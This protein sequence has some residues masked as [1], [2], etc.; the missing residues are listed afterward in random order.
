[1]HERGGGRPRN[2]GPQVATRQ[3]PEVGV[4]QIEHLACSI[5]VAAASG[6]QERGHGALVAFGGIAGRTHSE[7][8]SAASDISCSVAAPM[9]TSRQEERARWFVEL[10][11]LELRERDRAL[12]E[13]AASDPQLAAEVE[14]LLRLD[15]QSNGPIEAL[16]EELGPA[17]HS[18]F[19]ELEVADLAPPERLGPWRLGERL[20]AGGMGE[21]WAAE[22]ADAG[23]AQRAAIKLVR[24][25][26]ASEEVVRRFAIER[27]A[28][29]RLEHP[30]IARLLDGGVAPDGRPWFAMERVDGIAITTFADTNA[31]DLGSRLRLFLAVI[32]S[33]AFAHQALVVHRD[34]KPSNI[35]VTAAG[36]PKVLD[37]G[38]AKL[39]DPAE[40][41]QDQPELTHT[42]LLA[43]TPAYAAPEQFLGEPTTTATD[44]YALGAVLFELLTG[45]LPHQR[46]SPSLAVLLEGLERETLERPS[47]RLRRSAASERPDRAARLLEGDID[48]IVLQALAREPA[49]RYPTVAALGADI[50]AH[51]EGRPIAARPA[52]AFYLF[53]KFLGRHRAA[54]IAAL[55]VVSALSVS[56]IVSL[57][58]TAVARAALATAQSEARRAERVKDFL[59]SVFEQA[60][61]THTQGA[62][63]PARQIL[64]EGAAQLRT[65]LADE[66]EVRAELYDTVAQIQTSLGLLEEGLANAEAGAAERKRQFGDSSREYARS[67]VT[68][69]RAKLQQAQFAG[70]LEDFDHALSVFEA[71]VDTRSL[72]F[73]K[74]LSG[75]AEARLMLG[76][77]E[78]A[79]TDQLAAN[80]IYAAALGPEDRE[81]LG[82]LSNLAVIETRS[83]TVLEAAR[84]F[85]QV[86]AGL[87][88]VEPPDSA[89]VLDVVLN[90]ATALDTAGQS[91]EALALFERVVAGRRRIYGDQHPLL[92]E[93]LVIAGL[94]MSRA[95]RGDDALRALDEARA[96]Y[97]PLDHPELGTV[98]NF[99]GLTYA[100]LGRFAEAEA[101]FA[102]ASARFSR[103]LGPA[104]VMT[105]SANANRANVVSEL[106]R[107]D[108]AVELFA[109]AVAQLRVLQQLDNP[110]LL[111]MR[112]NWG[113]ALRRAGRFAEA[114][115]VLEAAMAAAR[116]QFGGDHLRI[117]EGSVE[118]ARLELAARTSTAPEVAAS[119]LAEAE[120][121]A[122]NNPPNAALARNLAAARA[123]L[124]EA[125]GSS[126]PITAPTTL[127]S[128]PLEPVREDQAIVEAGGRAL[129]SPGVRRDRGG[130]QLRLGVRGR[131]LRRPA[132]IRAAGSAA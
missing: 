40:G 105:V 17:L 28:L 41:N 76:D 95:G 63:V 120:R 80:A 48:T 117:A 15:R 30:G 129:P 34:L 103:D 132:A 38:L 35:L 92:A 19:S 67:R 81:T 51:L 21:V 29:A 116:E 57:Q 113:A 106:G 85:R 44:V 93:A 23:F 77:P 46:R 1:M 114:R 65:N 84:I 39:L 130:D 110:R 74:A 83:G 79:R 66:P 32:E 24:S 82:Q 94:R 97:A 111:R 11:D 121:I 14:R 3:G 96:I 91:T 128:T 108:E 70:A 122:E 33:V 59:V 68:V 72:D 88:R 107:E 64:A 52:S 61:P 36:A 12:E 56:L 104:H 126:A 62:D 131:R 99:S 13:I 43:L 37:F 47:Q 18:A 53:S 69:G 16:R 50:R 4:D 75:R 89:R 109:E 87:E 90:L 5:A 22:R 8:S 118:L 101:A 124:R 31:L 6:C 2:L 86:L 55:T 25:N 20:G 60:D 115:S 127:P 71:R 54:A 45:Q 49:R 7:D 27:R 10:C 123:E 73:A 112:L 26:M 78:Q 100:D 9:A 98:D 119:L 125:N 42:N 58:Q 102:A